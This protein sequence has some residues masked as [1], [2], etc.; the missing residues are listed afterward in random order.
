[1]PCC[2]FHLYATLVP[3]DNGEYECNKDGEYLA[4]CNWCRLLRWIPEAD[5]DLVTVV[6]TPQESD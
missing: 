1:M 6:V 4:R 5:I 2:D 3:G